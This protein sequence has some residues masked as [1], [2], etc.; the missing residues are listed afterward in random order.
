MLQVWQYL[1]F[2]P[3]ISI[4]LQSFSVGGELSQWTALGAAADIIAIG[5]AGIDDISG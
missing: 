5:H 3:F 2:Q 4:I 1:L